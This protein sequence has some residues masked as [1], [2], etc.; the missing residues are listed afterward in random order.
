MGLIAETQTESGDMIRRLAWSWRKVLERL[1]QQTMRQIEKNPKF[2]VSVGG[3]KD[4]ES[5]LK[6]LRP[7]C[8]LVHLG[9]SEPGDL[10]L[11]SEAGSAL[12]EGRYLLDGG[13]ANAD[14]RGT[15][16]AT[17]VPSWRRFELARSTGVKRRKIAL[18]RRKNPLVGSPGDLVMSI[19]RL[20][21]T[22]E[23][24]RK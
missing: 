21:E 11:F 6:W 19:A 5:Q 4:M 9:L 18:G 1:P 15:E 12:L 10:E 2:L 24:R 16:V 20:I 14:N 13:N 3:R 23:G 7:G 17:R 8:P 22:K